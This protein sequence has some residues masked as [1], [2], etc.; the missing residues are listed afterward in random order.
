M[1]KLTLTD[2]AAGYALIATYNANNAL[3]EAALE[4]TVSRDGTSPNTMSAAFDMNSQQIVNLPTP[5]AT[6]H[7]TSKAY[8]DAQ[9]SALQVQ[10]GFSAAL[11][12]DFTNTVT[13]T[14]LAIIDAG[15]TD[16]AT[17]TNDDTDM[18]LTS[19]GTISAYKI[20]NMNFS[21]MDGG[22]FK[23][24]NVAED[25]TLTMFVDTN[26]ADITTDSGTPIRVQGGVGNDYIR[27]DVSSMFVKEASAA[28]ADVGAL[29]QIWVKDN[30]PNDLMFTDDTG[31]DV[32][33]TDDGRLYVNRLV[34]TSDESATLDTTLSIDSELLN[35]VIPEANKLYKLTAHLLLGAGG[36]ASHFNF[37]FAWDNAPVEGTLRALYTENTTTVAADTYDD[38]TGEVFINMDGPSKPGYLV[39]DVIFLA[40][41]TLAGNI[42]LMWAQGASNASITQVR[43]GSYLELT[44]LN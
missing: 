7:A 2:I 15:G 9:I 3:I 6:S 39:V 21:L 32:Q 28:G 20:V 11:P 33:I 26:W 4:N 38:V 29:G 13:A 43:L 42:D 5:T 40:H 36:A 30:A 8:V 10:T 14:S 16:Y 44:K 22:V 41:A 25:M 23:L 18:F 27:F 35:L 31:Q 19:N 1:A 34:K 37:K 12:Y 17:W 24:Y